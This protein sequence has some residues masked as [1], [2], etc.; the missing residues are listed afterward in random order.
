M[1]RL[2]SS[3]RETVRTQLWPLPVAGVLFAVLAGVLLPRLDAYVDDGL[4]PWL[5]ALLFGGDGGAA[6]TLLDAISSSLITVT[7]LTFS[8]TIVTLQLASSQFSPRLLRTFSSDRFI[9]ATLAIFLS[10]FTFALT[11]LRAVRSGDNGATAFVP[12]LS[13]TLAFA[14]TIVSVVGL[15]LFLAHLARQIRVETM[16]RDVHADASAT[17]HS[18]TRPLEEDT[19]PE[20]AIPTPPS[21]AIVIRAPSSGFV[22]SFDERA[23][24]AAAT[25]AN[26]C[27]LIESYPGSSIV[28]GVPIGAAWSLGDGLSDDDW[29]RLQGA[30]RDSIGVGFERTSAQDISY[31][32][33][34]LTDVVNKALSPGINDPTTAIHG[35]SHISAILCEIAGRTL[36]SVVLR[37]ADDKVRVVLRR[38]G[39]AEILDVAIA[40]PRLYGASDPQVMARLFRLLEEVAWHVRDYLPIGDQLRRLRTSLGQSNF[41]DPELHDME[42][43]AVRVERVMSRRS[44]EP[45]P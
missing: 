19:R 38:A 6:R 26:A 11:V 15:V 36:H 41:Q 13:V 5:G 32:L 44:D 23:L 10:T 37:D 25:A 31:G 39:F 18:M 40:Q 27:L 21:N 12:R 34:Q 33:R 45:T 14:L 43:A 17:V 8:L 22:T 2:L 9:Q 24:C 20:P 1:T 35:L 16:L 4:P 30:L 42:L 3:A 29:N 28:E 7:S